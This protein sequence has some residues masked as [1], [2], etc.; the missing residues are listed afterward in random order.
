M[1]EQELESLIAFL[2]YFSI[3]ANEFVSKSEPSRI[4]NST[5]LFRG[6]LERKNTGK[7]FT[8]PPSR[9]L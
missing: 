4:P 8:Q 9:Q 7:V 3:C 1:F 6:Y 5:I 2:S